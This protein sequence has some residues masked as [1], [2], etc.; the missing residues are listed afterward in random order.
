MHG[1]NVIP[2][3]HDNGM[4]L[5]Y[6][7]TDRTWNDVTMDRDCEMTRQMAPDFGG[8]AVAMDAVSVVPELEKVEKIQKGMDAGKRLK[9][10][11][12]CGV[13]PG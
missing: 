12:G 2:T 10:A 3:K 9:A 13:V 6:V 8:L 5:S 1:S 11:D 4:T 7:A